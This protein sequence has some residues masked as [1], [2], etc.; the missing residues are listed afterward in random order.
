MSSNKKLTLNCIIQLLLLFLFLAADRLTKLAAVNSLKGKESIVLIDN[1][2]ELKYLENSGAAFGIFQNRQWL[3]YIITAVVIIIVC[4]LWI[5][6]VRSS[7]RYIKSKGDELNNK[8]FSDAM[9]FNY[10]LI[11][12]AAGAL[13]NLYD[14][15]IHSYVVDF[16]YIKAVNFPVFNFADICVTG[17]AL[18]VV[19]FFIFIYKED[20]E[21][22][23]FSGRSK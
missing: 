10:I 9:F 8:T 11:I 12:L 4:F 20:K 23:V 13:G 21:L 6:V 19:I 2:L 14:R 3:F 17:A 1:V 18:L 16:I 15:I 5:R 7:K 22:P